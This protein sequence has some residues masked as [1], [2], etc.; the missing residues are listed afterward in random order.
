MKSI[1]IFA[2]TLTF[3]SFVKSSESSS[4]QQNPVYKCEM[5]ETTCMFKNVVLNSTHYEWQPA[6]DNPNVVTKVRFI[7]STIPVVTKGICEIFLK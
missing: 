7:E 3:I 4:L 2:V 5:E 6:S 1:I